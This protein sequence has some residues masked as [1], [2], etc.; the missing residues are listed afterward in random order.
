M[1]FILALAATALF[2]L[3]STC[4]I[5]VHGIDNGLTLSQH[6]ARRHS[7]R[8]SWGIAD[9]LAM[10][11]LLACAFIDIGPRYVLSPI[12]YALSVL[13]LGG[14]LIAGIFPHRT[15]ATKIHLISAWGAVYMLFPL[16][17][18]VLIETL[19]AHNYPLT[20]FIII[21][22]IYAIFMVTYKKV[23][24]KSF[25][26]HLLLYENLYLASIFAIFVLLTFG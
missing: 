20:I 7:T 17:I 22:I 21:Y 11:T 26:R 24:H 1:F 3:V 10:S 13:V 19:P 8:V 6:V 15:P 12:F 16:A 23:R 5:L 25:K 9:V 4:G 14:M 18:D 2:W